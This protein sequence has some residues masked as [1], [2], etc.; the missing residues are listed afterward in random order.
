[1]AN[2]YINAHDRP[3]ELRRHDLFLDQDERHQ[4]GVGGRQSKLLHLQVGAVD[5]YTVD[6][7]GNVVAAGTVTSAG[8][9]SSRLRTCHPPMM[10]RR[11][12]HP[13]PHG[14]TCFWPRAGVIN[15]HAGDVTITH[16]ADQLIFTGAA[17]G[18]SFST[19][20]RRQPMMVRRSVVSD[21]MVRPLSGDR[22]GD[23]F[24]RANVRAYPFG[25]RC[26]GDHGRSSRDHGRCQ[27]GQR[28]D[29]GR[30]TD[31]NQQDTLIPI[32]QYA[33]DRRSDAHRHGDRSDDDM[34]EPW[35]GDNRRYQWRHHRRD[36]DRRNHSGGNY[37]DGDHR[38]DATINDHR[39][40]RR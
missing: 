29:G 27:Y 39:H 20:S 37:W 25:W 1:M 36:A 38:N 12:A 11:S 15:W 23:Q 6:K 9:I 28:R 40:R 7:Y 26:D 10:R 35:R 17:S 24:R 2:M 19:A 18:Y 5:K 3:V 16:A 14:P 8:V 30:R 33:D 13:A 4:R 34:V 31:A 32:D 22:R 21:G